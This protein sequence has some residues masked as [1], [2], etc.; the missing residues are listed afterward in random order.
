MIAIVAQI[1]SFVLLL[2]GTFWFGLHGRPT[3]MGLSILAAAIGLAFANLDKIE[4]F[5]G[6]GFEVRMLKQQV[7][8]LI[9]KEAEPPTKDESAGLQVRGYGLDDETRR[10]LLALGNSKY[11]WRTQSGIERESGV[12]L[13]E[14]QKALSWL[15]KN[16]LVVRSGTEASANWGLS[17]EGRNLYYAI[18]PESRAA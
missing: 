14:L 15:A 8:A 13:L 1:V 18:A 2:A 17:E 10:V 12:P 11:T 16:E 6:G 4:W 3:E 7:E 9:A 5:K